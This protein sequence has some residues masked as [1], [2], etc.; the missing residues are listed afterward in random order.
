MKSI[1][2]AAKTVRESQGVAEPAIAQTTSSS[3]GDTSRARSERAP[4][5]RDE[6]APGVR[7]REREG[8]RGRGVTRTNVSNYD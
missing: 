3:R 8:S 7:E 6:R 4:Q 2:F 5:H 1:V